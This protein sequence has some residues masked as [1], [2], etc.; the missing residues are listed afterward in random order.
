M[1]G[2]ATLLLLSVLSG[3]AAAPALKDFA[4][5]GCSLFPDGN[6]RDPHLWCD[7]C[8]Q[9][10][11]AYWRGGTQDDRLHADEQLRACVNAKTGDAALAQT[12]FV[13]VRSGGAPVFPTGYRWGYGW[14]YGR[15]Y[16]PL[17]T[18]EQHL[19]DE[20]LARMQKLQ[21]KSFCE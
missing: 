13:G 16:A 20:V 7:C 10:D 2:R 21:R 19:V 15:G 3:C 4:S 11:L 9:H 17:S 6:T 5:D 12:M 18:A 1:T 8:Y 14:N